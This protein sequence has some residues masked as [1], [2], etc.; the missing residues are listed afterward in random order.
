MADRAIKAQLDRIEKKLDVLLGEDPDAVPIPT[1]GHCGS[2][3]ILE[4]QAFGEAAPM[5]VCRACGKVTVPEPAAKEVA[6][7]G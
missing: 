3:D 5:I 1:C 7:H 2:E 4:D 6:T